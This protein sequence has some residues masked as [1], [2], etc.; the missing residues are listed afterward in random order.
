M[1]NSKYISG[2]NS[3]DRR[4]CTPLPQCSKFETIRGSE[5]G[6]RESLHWTK[7]VTERERER[8]RERVSLLP[9]CIFRSSFASWAVARLVRSIRTYTVHS[10]WE[11]AKLQ[12]KQGLLFCCSYYYCSF[13]LFLSPRSLFFRNAMLFI[14]ENDCVSD[15]PGLRETTMETRLCAKTWEKLHS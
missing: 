15:L 5:G 14:L 2:F 11:R 4:R 8:E 1:G 6:R 10:C 9:K 12:S 13:S 7:G 3:K